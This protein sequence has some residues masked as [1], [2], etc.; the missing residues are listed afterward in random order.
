MNGNDRR[1]RRRT[2]REIQQQGHADVT[3][4]LAAADGPHECPSC[5]HRWSGATT[6]A[7]I[8]PQLPQRSPVDR[9]TRLDQLTPTARRLADE[10][11][12]YVDAGAFDLWLGPCVVADVV[13]DRIF[14]AA[15]AERVR[16]IS[17]RFGGVLETCASALAGRPMRVFVFAEPPAIAEVARRLCDLV[18]TDESTP[19]ATRRPAGGAAETVAEAAEGDADA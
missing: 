3:A 8:P 14:V 19:P 16:W 2:K 13:D 1:R 10:A 18:S 7:E 17:D 4:L 5:G 6:P 9:A 11:R 15:P 12:R